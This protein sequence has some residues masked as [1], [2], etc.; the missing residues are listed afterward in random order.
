MN[1]LQAVFGAFIAAA[2]VIAGVAMLAGAAWALITAGVLTGVGTV[3]LY[4]P[5]ANGS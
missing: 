3:V 2:L 4:D 1:S 5:K